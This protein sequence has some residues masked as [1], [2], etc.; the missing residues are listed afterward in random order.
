MSF[1]SV[2]SVQVKD[3]DTSS[4]PGFMDTVHTEIFGQPLITRNEK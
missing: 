2:L 4:T 1:R 3:R